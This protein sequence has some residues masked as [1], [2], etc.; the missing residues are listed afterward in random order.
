MS[1]DKLVYWIK[2]DRTPEPAKWF[3]IHHKHMLEQIDKAVLEFGH[4]EWMQRV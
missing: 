3:F 1:Y 2:F 4:I